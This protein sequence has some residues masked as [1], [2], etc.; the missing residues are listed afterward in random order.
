M[1]SCT[2]T[3]IARPCEDGEGWDILSPAV[4]LYSEAPPQGTPLTAGSKAGVL[5]ILN[6]KHTLKMPQGVGGFVATEAPDLKRMPASAQQVLFQLKA[7]AENEFAHPSTNASDAHAD[8]LVFCAPQAG[9]FY[10]RSDPD[11]PLYVETGDVLSPG[12]TIG[13][14]EVMKTFNP[15]RYQPQ[16][17]LPD[18]A[19][20]I[21]FLVEDSTDIEEGQALVLLES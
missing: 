12:K 3:L 13:L 14:L 1:S 9:R 15:V 8:G 5:V 7:G 21:R 10:R 2:F 20:I 19:K 16:S 18:E 6:K 4:G 11:S 17:G